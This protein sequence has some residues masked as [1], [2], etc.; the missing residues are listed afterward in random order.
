MQRKKLLDL[1]IVTNAYRMPDIP[2]RE[3]NRI[4]LCYEAHVDDSTGEEVLIIHFYIPQ[5]NEFYKRLFVCGEKWFTEYA[6]GTVNNASLLINRYYWHDFIYTPFDETADSKIKDYVKSLP[7][8]KKYE[9]NDYQFSKH[10]GIEV[11]SDYQDIIRKEKLDAKY[12][13]IKDSASKEMLEIYP[14]PEK[15]KKWISDSVMPHYL[16]YVYAK[17]KRVTAFCS[18][19]GEEVTIDRPHKGDAVRCPRCKAKCEAKPLMAYINSCGFSDRVTALYVQPL[20]NNR[21]CLRHYHIEFGYHCGSTVPKKIFHENERT[22]AVIKGDSFKEGNT[23]IHDAN[24]RGGEWRQHISCCDGGKAYIYPS[25]LNQILKKREGF[26]Q[27]H[28]DY[29]K[30]ARYCNPLNLYMLVNASVGVN[31]LMNLVNGRLYHLAGD[32]INVAHSTDV[33]VDGAL[34]AVHYQNC[35]A[36]RKAFGITKDDL[37]ALQYI[38]PTLKEFDCYAKLKNS[39]KQEPPKELKEYFQI[40]DELGH[41]EK[42]TDH[43]IRYSSIH[44]FVKFIKR[45]E[46]ERFFNFRNINCW[47]GCN[48]KRYFLND[49]FDYIGFAQ[50]LEMDLRDLNVLYPKNPR[51][52]HDELSEIVNSKEFE[53]SELPQIE[54][55]YAGY[56]QMFG[57]SANGLTIVPPKRHNDVKREGKILQHCVATYAK[58]IAVGETIILFIRQ[59]KEPDTPFFTLNIDPGNYH[60]I[61]CRG[62][63]NCA[64]PKSVKN[65]IDQWYR[66]VI[67]PLRRNQ[68]QCLKTAS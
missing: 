54:R 67:E 64:Y 58:R 46:T 8:F 49:Y 43:I 66:D 26:R 36:L 53:K 6:D 39:G 10:S 20:K 29:N 30:I 48:P 38:D 51:K 12:E 5:K 45:L 44:Q 62:L 21:V 65:F 15:F 41:L 11:V 14:T 59:E 32:V 37:P 52:A 40:C 2:E 61:Q 68:K 47:F 13:R 56:D 34:N 27:Y 63:Q 4:N 17:S 42:I 18:H 1:P 31:S 28:V 3:N 19:C 25:N 9:Y 57:Y 35:G 33:N 24:Y 60:M 7:T 22:F 23:Y 55:Q 50:L 16:F